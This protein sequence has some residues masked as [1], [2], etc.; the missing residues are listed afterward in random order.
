[1]NQI[2]T[3]QIYLEIYLG[4]VFM[5][6]PFIFSNDKGKSN[7]LLPT[8]IL[9][10]VFTASLMYYFLLFSNALGTMPQGLLGGNSL[11][12]ENPMSSPSAGMG[13]PLT[14]NLSA[15]YNLNTFTGGNP[16]TESSLNNFSVGNPPPMNGFN[17]L[18]SGNQPNGFMQNQVQD[19]QTSEPFPKVDNALNTQ[20]RALGTSEDDI[21]GNNSLGNIAQTDVNLDNPLAD[22]ASETPT[23]ANGEYPNA[24]NKYSGIIASILGALGLGG[25]YAGLKNKLGRTGGYGGY[26]GG[27][28]NYGGIGGGD[29]GGYGAYG[30]GTGGYGGYGGGSGGYGGFGSGARNYGGGN[31]GGYGANDK[32]GTYT[33]ENHTAWEEE[34]LEIVNRYR[35][36]NGL[37]PLELDDALTQSAQEKAD[38]LNSSNA[39]VGAG[40]SHNSPTHGPYP[41]QMLNA[42]ITRPDGE[43]VALSSPNPSPN[44]V[45]E[46]FRRSP[47]HNQRML[48][49]SARYIAVGNSGRYSAMQFSR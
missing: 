49:P 35:Q 45:F 44:Q 1:M 31:S 33:P 6:F 24:G 37:Q 46:Q 27:A 40:T 30:G 26:G 34:M 16:S 29:T 7:K 18:N 4:G 14:G 2:Y 43:N 20:G 9:L 11:L 10:F 39:V 36:Q 15:P 23:S 21:S 5:S 22:P 12:Q 48:S 25:A 41:N 19:S 32:T 38:E 8:L 42:G 3:I 28:D 17:G 47:G 13:S